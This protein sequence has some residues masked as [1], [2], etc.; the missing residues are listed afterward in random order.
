[1]ANT[2]RPEQPEQDAR[3]PRVRAW[4][5]WVPAAI[6]A[7]VGAASVL[8]VSPPTAQTGTPTAGSCDAVA[9]TSR[10][11]P[12]VVTVNVARGGVGSGVVIGHNGYI[13]TNEH[14]ISAAAATGRGIT[15]TLSNGRVDD[16]TL[17]GMD[18]ESD[19]AV[20]KVPESRLPRSASAD[21]DRLR[22]GQPVVALGAPL[23]LSSTVTAGII[24]AMGRSVQLPSAGGDLV[25]DGMIQTDASINPGNSGGA[26][27]DCA[28]RLIG[29]NT[30]ISTVPN[31]NGTAGGGSVGIGFAVPSNRALKI[32]SDLI[33]QGPIQYP[34]FGIEVSAIP[35]AVA[36]RWGIPGGLFV[37]SVDAGGSAA[38]G[39]LRAGDVITS[40]NGRR[41]DSP[42]AIGMLMLTSR[43]GDT[44]KVGY[45]RSGSPRTAEIVLLARG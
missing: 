39:G 13:I 45:L 42:D 27:V 18:V 11:L 26:L 3:R 7:I 8:L 35:P 40:I 30:A 15:V 32:A 28:G 21:S 14:V 31:A 36:E 6:I 4:A 16:A 34:H 38:A 37:E 44:V 2:A 10:A 22:V 20:L 1:M 19:I 29:V 17:V 5:I 9:V 23:G 12:S 25:I 24:S 33:A 41:A 43:V